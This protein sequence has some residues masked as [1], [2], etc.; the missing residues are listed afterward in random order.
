MISGV[1]EELIS[2]GAST[3][4]HDMAL[5]LIARYAGTAP[6]QEIARRFALQFHQD[7][8]T[9][10]IVFEGK[11]DHGDSDIQSAQQWLSSHFSVANPVEEMIKRSSRRTHVQTQIYESDKR[12]ADCVR[13]AS[14]H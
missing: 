5:H 9:P 1:H 4:W 7:G 2:S 10:Y 14:S 3:S 8:L 13:A 12:H 6:A 11:T